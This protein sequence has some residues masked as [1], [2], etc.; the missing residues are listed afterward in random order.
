MFVRMN[1]LKVDLLIEVAVGCNRSLVQCFELVTGGL[2]WVIEGQC[3]RSRYRQR[4]FRFRCL[5]I[6]CDFR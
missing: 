5:G 1:R 6:I 3:S 4:A 2:T